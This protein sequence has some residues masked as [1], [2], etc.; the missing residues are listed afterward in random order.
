MFGSDEVECTSIDD[1]GS[2]ARLLDK[3]EYGVN[4]DD[5]ELIVG[6]LV[7]SCMCVVDEFAIVGFEVLDTAGVVPKTPRLT[8]I[9][10]IKRENRYKLK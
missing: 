6:E 8:C 5:F 7:D 4:V 1:V 9:Q 3:E 10:I 2:D